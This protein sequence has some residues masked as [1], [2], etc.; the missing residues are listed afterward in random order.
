MAS[1]TYSWNTINSTQTDGDSPLDETLM[2]AI[3]QNLA[4]LEEWMGDGYAQAK[5]HDHDGVNSAVVSGSNVEL[6][7]FA[8]L[9]ERSYTVGDDSLISSD[10]ETTPPA[11]VTT[12]QLIK[13]I[14]LSDLLKASPTSSLRIKFELL[15]PNGT[16][17][18]SGQIYRNGN[19]VG[20]F[21]T[22]WSTS[23][24]TYSEDISGWGPGDL[25]QLYGMNDNPAVGF[26]MRNF[27]VYVTDDTTDFTNRVTKDGY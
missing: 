16:T 1:T 27:R 7:T 23:Y 20:T 9:T 15:T 18:C 3:R 4:T 19:A 2:E 13:E 6:D 25:V 12:L 24:V 26:S 10:T 14:R 5:D 21:Q 11:S 22:T 8:Y 17:Y